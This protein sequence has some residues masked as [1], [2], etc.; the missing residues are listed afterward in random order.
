MEAVFHLTAGTALVM[1]AVKWVLC[2]GEDKITA[3]IHNALSLI[4]QG[5][6]VIEVP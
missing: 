6:C 2:F 1:C 4:Y 5:K 3:I